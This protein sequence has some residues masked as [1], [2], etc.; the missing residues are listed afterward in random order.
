M[1][2]VRNIY[3][4]PEL[5]KRIVFTFLMLVVYRVGAHIPTPGIDLQALGSFFDAARGTMLGF[6]DMF[7][8]G[9]LRR[10]TIFALGIMPYINAAIILELLKV[11]IPHL[12]RLAKEGEA[13]RKKLTQYT[14]YGTIVI[15]IVQATGISIGLESMSAPNGAAIVPMPGLAFRLLTI[16]TLT[17]GTAFIMWLGEQ[18]SERGIGNGISLIIF[19]GIVVRMPEA[20]VKTVT[21]WRS[22]E[23]PL[24]LLLFL[25]VMTVAVVAVI[26][27]AETGQ[28]KIPVQYAR[29]VVG[30]KMYGGQS[31]Y[32]PLKINTSGVIPPIFASSIIMFPATVAQFINVPFM[33]TVSN[34]LQPGRVL[35]ESI[36]VFLIVF[37]CYFYTAVVF[38]PDDLADNLKKYGGF[39]PGIRPG[40]KTAAY[41]DRVLTRI[42]LGG[43]VY[44][45]AICVLPDILISQLN[46]PFYFGGTA[47][48]ISVVVA[49]D[50]VT[51]IESHLLTRHYKGFL[52][53]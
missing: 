41:I 5:R 53:K 1:E 50:T 4:I 52:K 46:V 35:Y 39:I 14:R 29:R 17:S 37:F 8:G 20:V 18:I 19:A 28:R 43:A 47:L 13:G 42:T 45:S 2:I 12:A 26:V 48:L 16:I 7:S 34:L 24:F 27:F 3:N 21:L 10:L 31:T 36:F 6:F 30:R 38:N 15:A 32:I 44:V 33:Q 9:A 25:A 51:Q 49:K 23:M 11:V 22:G 40:K